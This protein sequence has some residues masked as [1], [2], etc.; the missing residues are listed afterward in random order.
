MGEVTTIVAIAGGIASTGITGLVTWRVSKNSSSVELAKVE[1]ENKR[2][3]QSNREEERRNRQSTYHQHINVGVEL[4]QL[5]GS[6]PPVEKIKEIQ[7]TFRYLHAGVL[8]FA[9]PPVRKAAYKVSNLYNEVGADMSQQRQKD[10]GK[11][12]AECWR[13]ASSKL[14]EQFGEKILELTDLMHADVTRGIAEDPDG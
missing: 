6:A 14:K 8:L 7:D 12:P 9:P 11:D 2:L 1:A 4:F 10:P 3:R 13:D 5:M